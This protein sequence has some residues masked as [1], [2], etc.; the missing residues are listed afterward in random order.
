MTR[1]A[2]PTD[3]TSVSDHFGRCRQFTIVDIDQG[4]VIKKESIENPGHQPGLLPAF[5]RE[6]GVTCIIASGMGNRAAD[7]FSQAGIQTVVGVHGPVDEV[8]Q[9]FLEGSLEGTGEP[10][11]GEGLGHGD[12]DCDQE[13]R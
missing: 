12:G 6:R 3:G 13:G 1:I 5:L 4:S 2:I 7:L 11:P 10:C 8:I 9:H